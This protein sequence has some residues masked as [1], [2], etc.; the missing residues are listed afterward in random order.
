MRA[1]RLVDLPV[2][3]ALALALLL[4]LNRIPSVPELDGVVACLA[5]CVMGVFARVLD[6]KDDVRSAM[7]RFASARQGRFTEEISTDQLPALFRKWG[8]EQ[9]CRNV[10]TLS[11]EGRDVLLF[12]VEY[13]RRPPEGSIPRIWERR[14]AVWVPQAL[15]G[16]SDF[17]IKPPITAH[18]LVSHGAVICVVL[19]IGTLFSAVAIGSWKQLLVGLAFV[20]LLILVLCIVGLFLFAKSADVRSL[21]PPF[22][23]RQFRDSLAKMSICVS[24]SQG[25]MLIWHDPGRETFRTQ[26]DRSFRTLDA[27]FP[28]I[29]EGLLAIAQHVLHCAS[30]PSEPI[31]ELNSPDRT[32]RAN[33][34]ARN[35]E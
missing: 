27:W 19:A 20:V 30:A 23:D 31:D 11:C 21:E 12:V 29:L 22:V 35:T 4:S 13:Y 10:V 14:Y 16:I 15:P 8:D 32:T 33:G 1:V 3:T 25:E 7:L 34:T 6:K 24:C 18:H 5:I 26:W 17:C 9:R 2:V 28:E